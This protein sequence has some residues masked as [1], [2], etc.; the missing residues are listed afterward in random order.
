ML[1]AIEDEL[2]AA[3]KMNIAV[4]DDEAYLRCYQLLS[5]EFQVE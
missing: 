3:R 4:D 1:K 5:E 2:S